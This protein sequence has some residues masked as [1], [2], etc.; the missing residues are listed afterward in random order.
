V[1]SQRTWRAGAAAVRRHGVVDLR[2]LARS[3]LEG[4]RWERD[5]AGLDVPIGIGGQ[6]ISSSH[7]V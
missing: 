3:A 2:R 7:G 5:I 4:A 6:I 1:L